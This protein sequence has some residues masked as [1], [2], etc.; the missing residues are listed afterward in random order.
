M[1]ERATPRSTWKR[2]KNLSLIVN[3]SAAEWS[4][5]LKFGTEFVHGIAGTL[6]MF[7]VKGQGQGHGVKV[8]GHGIWAPPKTD[9]KSVVNRQ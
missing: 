4:I 9:K 8:Q 3:N 5:S 6:Q 7:K 1:L 2:T